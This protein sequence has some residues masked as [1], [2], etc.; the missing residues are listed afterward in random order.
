[1]NIITKKGDWKMSRIKGFTLTC[2]ECGNTVVLQDKFDRC[3]ENIFI[4]TWMSCDIKCE[5]CENQVEE[6]A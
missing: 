5:N 2:N 3:T 6:K 4:N 1:M